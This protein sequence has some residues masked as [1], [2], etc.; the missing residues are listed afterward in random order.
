MHILEVPSFFT[1]Y[2]G[3][4]CLEQARALKALGHEVRILSNVQLGFTVGGKD[5][6]V[7]PFTRFEHERD[8]ITIYQSYQRGLPHMVHHNVMHWISIVQSMFEKYVQKY[9]KPDILH[10]HCA[11]WAGYAAMKISKQYQIPYV[12]T[13][14][15][16]LMLLKEEF[17]QDA[18]GAWQVQMLREAYE[19]ANMVVP[20]SEELVKDI[21]CYFGDN[22]KWQ[23]ISNTIDTNF[24]CYQPRKP[25]EGRAFRFC[26]VADN[27]YRKGYDVLIPAFKKLKE[28]DCEVEMKV[29]GRDT[30]RKDFLAQ[31]GDGIVSCGRIGKSEVRDLLYQSD[32]L[33]L[34]SRSEVQPLV[35]LEAM[36]TGIPVIA[37][38]CVP[39][40]L[41]IEGGCTIVPTDNV[42]AL[43]DAMK[44]V[45]EQTADGKLIS[46]KVKAMASPQVVGQKL[47]NLFCQLI[48]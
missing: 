19:N 32:A 36:S 24:F 40:N 39:Q 25:R 44:Q 3:E 1:P 48:S 17:G 23:F 37:T 14:H 47:S 29:A 41:R 8:G 26:C 30:D 10:A 21:S 27:T 43:A 38:E 13:E 35:L 6:V 7:L 15:L 45:M 9:G 22:Y 42:D 12:I 31:L 11:K 2:G 18:D 34:A 33:V 46:E 5:Y 20:V 4:F 16:P 28:S